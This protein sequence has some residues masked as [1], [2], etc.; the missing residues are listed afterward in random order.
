MPRN[1][2]NTLALLLL[3]QSTAWAQETP[4]TP[5]PAE[6]PT[7]EKASAPPAEEIEAP[8][9]PKKFDGEA[10]HGLAEKESAVETPSSEWEQRLDAARNLLV[11]GSFRE[12]AAAY[13][14][15]VESAEGPVTLR[16]AQELEA[17]AATLEAR[18]LRFVKA[19]DLGESSVSAK[20]VDKRTTMEIALL[21]TNAVFYGI[22]S[23]AYM[24]VLTE[25]QSAAGAILPVLGFAGAAAGAVALLDTDDA[26]LRYGVPQSAVSG[27]TIGLM[28]AAAWSAWNVAASRESEMLTDKQIATVV[29]LSAT[30]GTVGGGL[31]SHYY[32]VTPGQASY[33]SSTAGWS[34]AVLALVTAAAGPDDETR[35]DYAFLAA[36]L[37]VNVGAALGV[38][39]AD[40]VSPSIGRVLFLDLGAISG[41]LLFGGLYAAMEPEDEVDRALPAVLAGGIATG[42]TVA[43]FLTEDMTPDLFQREGSV[44]V[45]GV[46]ILPLAGGGIGLGLHGRL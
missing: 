34:G 26:P 25:P 36:A 23:G 38:F 35:E 6:E 40:A 22:G 10:V 45:E 15:L 28:E 30:L 8:P 11:L 18:E 12:A 16:L 21:Y 17:I 5:A 9:L 41:A 4:P 19:Q 31:V 24:A 27:L 43:W 14:A 3:F 39:T 46:G 7:G 42:L 37:G 29:W 1:L 32:G 20:A 44:A 13:H 33:V 2:R